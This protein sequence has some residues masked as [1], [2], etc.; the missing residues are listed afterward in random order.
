MALNTCMTVWH[1]PKTERWYDEG[2][3]ETLDWVRVA[4]FTH[5][6]WNPDSGSSYWLSDAEIAFTARIVAE[7]GLKTKSVHASNGRNPVTEFGA[8]GLDLKLTET[9]KDI[10]SPHDWQRQSGVELLQ[11]RIDLAVAMGSPDVVLHIDVT[12][13]VFDTSQDEERFFTPLFAS[14]DALKPYAEKCGVKIAVETLFGASAAT[15][16]ALYD[17]LF[18]RYPANYIGLCL[19]IGHW[20]LSDPGGLSV[21]ES[22]GDRL[23]TTHIHDNFGAKDDHLLPF[24]GRIDWERVMAAIAQTP[25]EPPLTFETPQDRY[26]LPERAYYGRAQQVALRLEDMLARYRQHRTER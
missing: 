3:R 4:G 25:Y 19:D 23:C 26:G 13:S 10:L 1:W 8:K 21:I 16:L 12:D 18:A 22:F 2:I 6:N 5:I 7:A 14:L 24:D 11:N 15:Y 17:R 9:R 20:E